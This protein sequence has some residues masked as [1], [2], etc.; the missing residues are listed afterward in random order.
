MQRECKVVVVKDLEV[1]DLEKMWKKFPTASGS[2]PVAKRSKVSLKNKDYFEE[3]KVFHLRSIPTSV[4]AC[5]R[6]TDSD[7]VSGAS[8]FKVLDLP[9]ACAKLERQIVR[10]LLHQLTSDISE[11]HDALGHDAQNEAEVRFVYGDPL[12]KLI[13]KIAHD[14]KV[15][16]YNC[17]KLPLL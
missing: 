1:G 11:S 17:T 13:L 8:E 9:Q 16:S 12:L 14:C 6:M 2:Q 5:S 7:D 10:T 15:C 4:I 3:A